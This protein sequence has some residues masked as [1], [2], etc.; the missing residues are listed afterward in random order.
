VVAAGEH[1]G[2]D[3]V[4][5]ACE[6]SGEVAGLPGGVLLEVACVGGVVEFGDEPVGGDVAVD[7]FDDFPGEAEGAAA[8]AVAVEEVEPQW[9]DGGG[10]AVGLEVDEV[11]GAAR[12][13]ELALVAENGGDGAGVGGAAF[14]VEFGDDVGDGLVVVLVEDERVEA[15]D[16]GGGVGCDERGAE[17]VAFDFVVVWRDSLE[18]AASW[19]RFGQGTSNESRCS[20]RRSYKFS[21]LW[22]PPALP[23]LPSSTRS[24][25]HVNQRFRRAA[26]GW[27][28]A[29]RG[30]WR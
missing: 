16:D 20:H 19:F 1:G 23:C 12:E 3:A 22:W 24:A 6:G 30:R 4:A 2:F 8:L 10:R 11:A 9:V 25:F 17:D 13:V 27:R 28:G 7:G 14:A 15:G 26:F 18:A 5:F 29:D 21:R